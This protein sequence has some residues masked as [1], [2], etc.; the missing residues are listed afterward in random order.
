MTNEHPHI[1][2]PD[3]VVIKVAIIVLAPEVMTLLYPNDLPD[4]VL[5]TGDVDKKNLGHFR[6]HHDQD[7][8]R[9]KWLIRQRWKEAKIYRLDHLGISVPEEWQ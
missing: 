7:P 9:L 4:E 2:V 3:D 8:E 1:Q 6:Q 5:E